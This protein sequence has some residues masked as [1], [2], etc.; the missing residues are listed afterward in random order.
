MWKPQ[1]DLSSCNLYHG[2][3]HSICVVLAER[4][5]EDITKI[6]FLICNV[7]T[8]GVR[9]KIKSAPHQ[10]AS[11]SNEF[12][13]FIHR[14]RTLLDCEVLRSIKLGGM[15]KTVLSD[16]ILFHFYSRFILSSFF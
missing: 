15:K 10:F 6:L 5:E 2:T 7:S 13:S 8:F 4:R 12:S 3:E 16:S 14:K 1:K 9:D 11:C